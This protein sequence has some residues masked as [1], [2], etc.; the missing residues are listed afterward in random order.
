MATTAR[1]LTYG[2][3][4]ALPD[5]GKRYEIIDGELLEM[6]S[7]SLPHQ[8]ILGRLFGLLLNFLE[9]TDLGRVFPAPLDIRL[10]T[11]NIVQPDLV[12]FRK[13]RLHLLG[14]MPVDVVPDLAIEILSPSSREH[15][16][17]QKFQR[18]AAAGIPEY[19]LADLDIRALRGYT[20]RDG[21]YEPLPQDGSILRSRILPGLEFDLSVLFANLIGDN[22]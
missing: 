15:D 12:V 19:Y 6:P 8:D 16:E 18:Y 20:L 5:D 13:E 2:D 21:V 11:H 3:L 7:P 10:S 9:R 4:L 14:P 17:Q 22:R 1:L